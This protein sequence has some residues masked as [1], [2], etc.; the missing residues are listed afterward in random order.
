MSSQSFTPIVGPLGLW[1]FPLLNSIRQM[2]FSRTRL[3]SGYSMGAMRPMAE[4]AEKWTLMRDEK[5]KL[6][7]VEVHREVREHG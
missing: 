1:S 4:N 6:V 3:L 5:G 7:G 2:F